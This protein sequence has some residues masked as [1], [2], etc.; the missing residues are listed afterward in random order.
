MA[1]NRELDKARSNP[2]AAARAGQPLREERSALPPDAVRGTRAIWYTRSEPGTARTRWTTRREQRRTMPGAACDQAERR[3]S[4]LPC[5]L[6]QACRQLFINSAKA[7]IGEDRNHIATAHLRSDSLNDG[8]GVLEK[9]S[10]AAVLP[11]LCCEGGQF[12]ALVFR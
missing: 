11:D 12:Q 4:S 9:P 5:Q 2:E 3:K 8:I 10:A 1:R 6:T 7:A